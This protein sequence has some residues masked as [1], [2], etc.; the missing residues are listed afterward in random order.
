MRDAIEGRG[1]SSSQLWEGRRWQMRPNS[2]KRVAILSDLSSHDAHRHH[3]SSRSETL[4][5]RWRA[6]FP[7]FLRLFPIRPLQMM[8]SRKSS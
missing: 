3:F 4:N 2:M 8:K 5:L 6:Q 1:K 7:G